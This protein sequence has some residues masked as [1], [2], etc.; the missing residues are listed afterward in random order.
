MPFS[1]KSENVITSLQEEGRM[2]FWDK[3]E[4]KESKFIK[5]LSDIVKTMLRSKSTTYCSYFEFLPLYTFKS[6]TR[7]LLRKV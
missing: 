5:S 4:I 7:P 2:S 3:I 6:K 1:Y